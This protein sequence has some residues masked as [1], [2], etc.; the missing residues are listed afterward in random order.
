MD[1]YLKP[2]FAK[3]P[4]AKPPFRLSGFLCLRTLQRIVFLYDPLA[5]SFL[6]FFGGF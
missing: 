2:P 4:F 3:P 6:S 1:E 5:L